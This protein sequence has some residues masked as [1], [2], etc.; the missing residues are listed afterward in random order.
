[1]TVLIGVLCDDGVVIGS[2]GAA[3]FGAVGAEQTTRQPT[4]KISLIDGR[5]LFA[6]SGH[7]GLGQRL[8]DRFQGFVRDNGMASRNISKNEWALREA[9]LLDVEP[10]YKRSK[11]LGV[12]GLDQGAVCHSV[13]A[14][15]CDKQLQ[16]VEVEPRVIVN[17]FTQALPTISV[18]SGSRRA[19]PFLAFIR[20]VMWNDRLPHLAEG[21][22]ATYWTLK[23]AILTDTGGVAEP[24]SICT[25]TIEAGKP[26]AKEHSKESLAELDNLVNDV[27][28][29]LPKYFE[30]DPIPAPAVPVLPDTKQ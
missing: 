3:T 21:E 5:A 27:E 6:F 22:F 15:M 10:E 12:E 2:D 23:H 16:L 19:D 29:L 14:F 18:G 4:R 28:T 25:L 13:L 17:R 8:C 7:T 24:I 20:R 9:F 1:M 30:K 26:I 11:A